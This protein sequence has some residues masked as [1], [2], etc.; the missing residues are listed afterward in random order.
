MVGQ[1]WGINPDFPGIP[2]FDAM[3]RTDPDF[4]LH[5]GDTIYADNPLS[6]RVV[7]PDGRVWR[8][9]VTP[10]K[11]KVAETLDELRG[12]FRYNLLDPG[13]RAFLAG[14]PQVNQWDDHETHNNWFPGEI[15]DDPRYT[16]RRADVLSARARQ[17]FFEYVPVRP[18]GPDGDGRIY[19]KRSYGPLLDVFV[20]DMR[21]YR[22]RND[23]DPR[24][25]QPDGGILGVQQTRWLLRQLRRSTATWKV[26]AADQPI[27][28]QVPDG[29]TGFEAV[30]NLLDGPPAARELEIAWLLHRMQRHGVRNT[31]WLTTD[32]H[33]TSA[34]VYSPD[35]AA[36][37]DFDPF[38]E[39]VSGPVNAGA[40][41]A[42]PL[43]ATFGPEAVFTKAPPAP[44]SSPLDDFQFFGQVDID[45]ATKVLTVTLKDKRGAALWETALAPA[46]V[47]R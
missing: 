16:E 21:S 4:F 24:S 38:W 13:V 36:F 17:A 23:G 10:E 12:A 5:S 33:Y 41:P 25:T 19:R 34:N 46:R 45:A 39:F 40:F 47:P 8:N 9:L 20:L 43:D 7:L 3:L 32:V 14:V 1:G 37:Q 18:Q 6:E 44:N 2:I 30:S 11:A 31:L 28:I 26:I 42:G 22:D 27:G 29:T 15:L 35:R